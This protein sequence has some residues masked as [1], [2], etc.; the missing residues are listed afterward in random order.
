MNA[1]P[2][3][4]YTACGHVVTCQACTARTLDNYGGGHQCP[5]CRT[6]GGVLRLHFG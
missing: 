2:D 3:M 1:V 5:V 4:A 6:H